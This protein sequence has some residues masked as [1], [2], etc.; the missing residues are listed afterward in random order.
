MGALR[1][2][3]IEWAALALTQGEVLDAFDGHCEV[4][5]DVE[6]LE[7]APTRLALS[8]RG[9]ERGVVELTDALP[10][11][12]EPTLALMELDDAL[13][14]RFLDDPALRSQVAVYDLATLQKVN[15]VRASLFVHFEW[16]LRDVYGV[17]VLPAPAFTQGLVDRGIISLGMG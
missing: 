5:D 8:W 6:V 4:L 2:R 15:A 11:V 9:R 10:A 7:R 14:E 3:R 16:F 17:K 13:V 1:E 12:G